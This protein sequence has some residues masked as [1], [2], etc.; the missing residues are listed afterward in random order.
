MLVRNSKELRCC[1]IFGAMQFFLYIFNGGKMLTQIEPKNDAFEIC[2]I[3]IGD[4]VEVNSTQVTLW[5]TI[6]KG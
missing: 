3:Q 5:D 6:V 4:P 2:H 1:F